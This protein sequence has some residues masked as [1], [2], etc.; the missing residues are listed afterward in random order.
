MLHFFKLCVLYDVIDKEVGKESP[1]NH[2]QGN[3]AQELNLFSFMEVV[4]ETFLETVAI[5]K[6]TSCGV[7]F[8]DMVSNSFIKRK[9]RFPEQLMI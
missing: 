2:V 8:F 9:I 6:T 1:E 7:V 5:N 3:L 4:K